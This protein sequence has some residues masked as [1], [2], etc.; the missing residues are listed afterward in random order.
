LVNKELR[1]GDPLS[2]ILFN[3]VVDMPAILIA[4][5]NDD[6]RGSAAPSRRWLVYLAMCR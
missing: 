4:R 1:Q 5:A 3:I 6:G 2:L